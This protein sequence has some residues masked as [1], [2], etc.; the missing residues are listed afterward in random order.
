MLTPDGIVTLAQGRSLE[1]DAVA[2][3]HQGLCLIADPDGAPRVRT[4]QLDDGRERHLTVAGDHQR[5]EP[6]GLPA[7][8][9]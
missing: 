3:T 1:P 6:A 5:T 9:G 4:V 7:L 2:V 8:A